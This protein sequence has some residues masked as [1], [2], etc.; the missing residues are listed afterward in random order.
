MTIIPTR[1]EL[2][3]LTH[4]GTTIDTRV[5]DNGGRMTNSNLLSN[6]K[7]RSQ[8]S[9]RARSEPNRCPVPSKRHH[10]SPSKLDR[11]LPSPR[12]QQ[13]SCSD[14]RSRLPSPR[15]RGE[16]SGVRGSSIGEDRS[17]VLTR[18]HGPTH[19][20]LTAGGQNISTDVK[21]NITFIPA[22]LRPTASSLTSVWDFDN[23]LNTADVGSDGSVD[24]TYKFDAIGRRVFR[25]NGTTATVYVQAGQQTIAD[26]TA[27]SAPSSPTYRYVYA[28]YIDEPVLR[29]KPSGSE[30]LYYHR[31][32][33]YSVV[34]LT[35]SS[36][37]IVER[38]AYS[39]Y[40]VPTI[41][42]AAGTLLPVGS[43]DNRY[44]FTGRE[45]D[46]TLSLYHYRARM[47]DAYLGR[48]ASRNPIGF[49]AGPNFYGYVR[50][51]PLRHVDPLGFQ[52]Y[53]PNGEMFGE[54]WAY[55]D[56][57][58]QKLSKTLSY[59]YNFYAGVQAVGLCE[60]DGN[61]SANI[62]EDS[63]NANRKR[64]SFT[65]LSNLLTPTTIQ[66][67]TRL[68]NTNCVINTVA[69]ACGCHIDGK[70]A[71]CTADA[72]IKVYL[73]VKLTDQSGFLTVENYYYNMYVGV[74]KVGPLEIGTCC[75]LGSPAR[76]RK[77]GT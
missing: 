1:G 33:Q 3:Q 68:S 16:G 22:S 55:E 46:Q 47:Y 64:S 39:A 12:T 70:K 17:L 77:D 50:N 18:T 31:N 73:E 52:E 53:G 56:E 40:G 29:F 24:V 9:C 57:I 2:Y 26:Y 21:G 36:A 6:S 74:L 37:A 4:A 20:L 34:A 32:Q 43:V 38:Y 51:S 75:P 30:S 41:T 15:T 8:I 45:W 10:L 59:T 27:S 69:D 65:Q 7:R 14:S 25:D 63:S 19:E 71:A 11:C 61:M 49:I 44:L 67:T 23:R 35:N 62:Q 66:I 72:E 76:P 58:N 54:E 42:N 5:Y 28:S 60:D 48:F 13:A